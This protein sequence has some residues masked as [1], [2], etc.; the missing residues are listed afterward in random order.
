[1]RSYWLCFTG[2]DGD[3]AR[4]VN[5]R[6]YD[7]EDAIVQCDVFADGRPMD[8]WEW[9]RKVKAFDAEAERARLRA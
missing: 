4:V 1:M 3:A 2:A 8:L 9:G 6:A 7:D 5:F